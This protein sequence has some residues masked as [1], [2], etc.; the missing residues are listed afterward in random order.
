MLV[1]PTL[2]TVLTFKPQSNCSELLFGI[3]MHGDGP[4]KSV[5]SRTLAECCELRMTMKYDAFTFH[6]STGSCDLTNAPLGYHISPGTADATS[7]C[8]GACPTAPPTPTRFPGPSPLGDAEYPA[9]ATVMPATPTF[10]KPPRPNI[11]LFFG[12]DVGYGDLGCYGNPT[13][14]TPALDAMARTG[15]KMSQYYSAA[16]IC[17]PSRASLMSGRN[18]V[19]VGMYPGVLSPLSNGGLSLNE[20][21]VAD[22]LRSAG[23]RTGMCGKWHLG[24]REYHPTHH[25]FDVY[26]GAPMTQNECY[27]NLIAPGSTRKGGSFGPCPWFN[28][29]SDVPTWQSS[30]VFP[31]DKDA[32]DMVNVDQFYDVRCH[33][34]L[35]AHC[36]TSCFCPSG[37]KRNAKRAP[38]SCSD[39]RFLHC[40]RNRSQGLSVVQ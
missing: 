21:T 29:S 22:K 6:N 19:R 25:G 18:F 16:S 1:F 26:Y 34:R 2:I 39:T 36:V 4:V 40:R 37:D 5:T 24:T 14:M 35:T 3:G 12:D 23:Y 8:E 15:A 13:S 31:A 30:G 10:S 33:P 32:V 20:T 27:S 7:G 17:S 11:V 9:A 28:G 38:P